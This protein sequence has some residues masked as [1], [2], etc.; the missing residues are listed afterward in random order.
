[1]TPCRLDK[2]GQKP[3]PPGVVVE[4]HVMERKHRIDAFGALSLTG[5][6]ALLAFNQVVIK[7]TNDGL[8]PVFFAGLRSAFGALCIFGWVW[9]RGLEIDF[10]RRMLGSGLLIGTLFAAEF[11]C[12]FLSLDLTTVTRVSVIFYTMPIWLALAGHFLIAGER[13]TWVKACGLGLAFSGVVLV[14]ASRQSGVG[15]ASLL[16]DL[17]ALIAAMSWAGIALCV[18]LTRLKEVRPEA[19]LLWQLLVSA[20]LLLLAS[21]SFGPLLRDPQVIHWAGLAF[22]V[23]AIVSA[24]FLFWLWLLTIYPA[25]SVAAF[26]FLSPVFGVVFGCAL[27]GEQAGWQVWVALACVVLGLILVN[28][29]PKVA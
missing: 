16:G 27:L 26:S 18:R 2:E 20:P 21:L 24:G 6:A 1:M 7:L 9:L 14:I 23:V 28:R 17:L 15:Q 25:A 10:S 3:H 29:R 4:R 5:F 22:Q 11:L 19:Q 12:L 13:L 8:Q